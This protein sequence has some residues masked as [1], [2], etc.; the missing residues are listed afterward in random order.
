MPLVPA[1]SRRAPARIPAFAAG[2]PGVTRAMRT[3]RER[4]KSSASTASTSNPSHARRTAPCS[5]R[6]RATL[7]ARSMGMAKP[8]PSLPPE[9]DRMEALIPI[10]SPRALTSGPPE[11]PGLIEAS[12]WI[13]PRWK[14][15]SSPPGTMWRPSALTTPA[16]TEGSWFER[17]PPKGLPIATVHSPISRFVA[18]PRGATGRSVAFS[19]ARTAMSVAG[20][21]PTIRA[22][23]SRA[24]GR[25]T[26]IRV[27]PSTTWWLVSTVPPASMTKPE[28]RPW[29]SRKG[30]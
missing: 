21:D 20:S 23:K 3:P 8:S 16:V 28:P 1:R 26:R 10:T 24:S 14:P 25:V 2:D 6:S 13:M 27:A 17:R 30:R 4:P 9:R 11:L 5:A 19:S 12:V 18:V 7:S 29:V 15:S 22:S